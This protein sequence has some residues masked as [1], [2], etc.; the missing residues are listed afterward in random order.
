MQYT[1]KYLSWRAG[2]PRWI[3]GETIRKRGFK[4]RDLKYDDGTWMSLEHA[5]EAA[6]RLNEAAGVRSDFKRP[7]DDDTELGYVYFLFTTDEKVKIGY[8]KRLISRMSGL[9]TGVSS[10]VKALV[11]VRGSMADE[12]RLHENFYESRLRGEWFAVTNKLLRM[13]CESA[14]CGAVAFE[15]RPV[16]QLLPFAFKS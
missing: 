4:G 11:C 13:A 2:R 7:N 15:D 9:L 14:A 5:V 12:R 16:R 3:P 8:S 6:N 1:A 10:E